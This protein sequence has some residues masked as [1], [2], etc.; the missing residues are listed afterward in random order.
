MA[1]SL[2]NDPI[3]DLDEFRLR[4]FV[5]RMIEEGEVEVVEEPIELADIAAR[6][7]GNEKAVLFRQAGA[8]KSEIIGSMTGGRAR[9]AKAFGVSPADLLQE[10]NRRLGIPQDVIELDNG[11]APVHEVIMTGDDVD[12]TA[13]PVHLQHELDGAPYISASLDYVINPETGWTNTGARRLMLRGKAETGIDL[14]APSDL[15]AIYEKCAS[16]GDRLPIAFTVGAHPCDHLA[17]VMRL[18]VDELPLVA[19]LRGATLPVVK[20]VTNDIRV[21]AD[22]EYV[23]EGYLDERGHVE[24]EGPYGEFLGYY[25]VVKR[26]PVFHCTA[27]TRRK[28]ALFQTSTISGEHIGWTDT[29]QLNAIRAEVT[30]WRALQTAVREPVAINI[31]TSSGGS[32]NVRVAL[33]QRM[34]GEARNAIAAVMGSLANPK[35]V[36]VVDPDID[37]FDDAQMDWALATRFQADRDLVVESGFRALPLDPSLGGKRIGAKAGFDLTLPLGDRALAHTVP[38]SSILGEKS[39]D[40]VEAALADGPKSFGEIMVAVGSRDGREIVRALDELRQADRLDRVEDGHYALT[41]A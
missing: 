8:E 11:D 10:V 38:K 39:H 7:D 19:K 25:G 20:C 15:K 33:R 23:I 5:D 12:L 41:D 32:F 4:R 17:A 3:P 28:D 9:M 6:M 14:V 30:V 31:T 21:P 24:P 40:S 34:P 27:I 36:F 35:H 22:A 37:I 18:P 2:K 26:N 1:T 13:L 29:T 16:K